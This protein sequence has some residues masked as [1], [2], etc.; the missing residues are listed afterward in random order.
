MIRMHVTMWVIIE[1]HFVIPNAMNM[2]CSY[3]TGIPWLIRAVQILLPSPSGSGNKL[4]QLLKLF[5]CHGPEGTCVHPDEF[6]R[7]WVTGQSTSGSALPSSVSS[8]TVKVFGFVT[9]QTNSKYRYMSGSSKIQILF[10]LM[11]FQVLLRNCRFIY[12]VFCIQVWSHFD[13]L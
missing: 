13:V 2:I 12:Y 6:L 5:T 10:P 4:V 8:P 7:S 1:M 11:K 9:N 3:K